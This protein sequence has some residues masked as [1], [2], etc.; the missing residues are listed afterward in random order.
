LG[1][2]ICFLKFASILLK[3]MN[4]QRFVPLAFLFMIV[5]V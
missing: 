2:S 4:C 5:F 1:N 3:F